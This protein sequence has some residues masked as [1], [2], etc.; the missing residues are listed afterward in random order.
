M[1]CSGIAK[2]TLAVCL[3][4]FAALSVVAQTSDLKLLGRF[5]DGDISEFNYRV[6]NTLS[7]ESGSRIILRICSKDDLLTAIALAAGIGSTASEQGGLS[8]SL[9][10]FRYHGDVFYAVYSGC[11][12]K[13]GRFNTVEYWLVKN[14]AKL[15][16][17]SAIDADDTSVTITRASSDKEFDSMLEKLAV[18]TDN[19]VN[20]A[21]LIVGD[22]N[23]VPSPNMRKNIKK[24]ERF[25][26]ANEKC[27]VWRSVLL[28]G[29][30]IYDNEPEEDF[31]VFVVVA[32]T[33]H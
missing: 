30:D 18:S 28:K 22:Y 3:V 31:P 11:E 24:A 23:S 32:K 25:L 33:L 15:E 9:R 5:S 4:A 6:A 20:S 26:G 12:S 29:T 1:N 10:R 17:D 19:C 2:L 16:F 27:G 21:K 14:N 7:I 13:N 8:A